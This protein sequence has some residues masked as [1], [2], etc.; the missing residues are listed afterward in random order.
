VGR[1]GNP[2]DEVLKMAGLEPAEIHKVEVV[3]G[4]WRIPQVQ[5]TLMERTKVSQL[6]KTMN[7]DEAFCFGSALYAAS[8]STAFR[9]RKFGVHDIT[10]FPVSIDMDALGSAD[11]VEEDSEEGG[12]DKDAT[13]AGGKKNIKLFKIG[14]KIPSKRLLTF[15]RDSDLTFTLR[16]DDEVPAYVPAVI[17]RYNITGVQ[18]AV[19]KYPNGT[20]PKINVSFRLTRTGLVEVDRAEAAIEEMVEV[21]VCEWVKSNETEEEAAAEEKKEGDEEK[22]EGEE[23]K[24]EG[25]EEKKEGDEEKKE[26]EEEKKEGEEEKK[27]GDEEKKEGEE[28]KKDGDEEKK[29]GEEEKKEGEEEKK[30]GEEEKKDDKKKKKKAKKVR[31]CKMK[32]EKQIHR[33]ALK[34]AAETPIPRPFTAEQFKETKQQLADYDAREQ[35]I[36]DRASAF[37][38]L[39]SYIYN[40][41]E[42][43]ENNEEMKEVTTDKMRKSFAEDLK[44][45]GTW[46]EDD[47]W[48]APTEKLKEKLSELTEIGDPIFARM[49]QRLER[50]D[51][52]KKAHKV[53]TTAE[54]AVANLTKKMPWL[55][56]S[57]TEMVT[58]KTEALRTWL[59][60]V[61]EKQEK[62]P[63]HEAPVFTVE[64]LYRKFPAIE[65]SLKRLARVPKPIEKKEKKDKKKDKKEDKEDKEGPDDAA[66]DTEGGG[67]A[68][69]KEGAEGDGGKEDEKAE[70]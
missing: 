40:V 46:I 47:G 28:E 54:G 50:P 2:V 59:A 16:Y 15:K 43:L 62:A 18:K 7:S 39:E 44:K 34:V 24:K 51:A 66:E 17:A 63:A 25:E 9:L 4:G 12:E 27:D 8:L 11:A 1:V 49:K 29:E 68:E 26:G 21:E 38:S 32:E 65:E 70:L 64:E 30:E 56:E 42:K 22:K 23:E 48:E 37:N 33:V 69:D 10:S 19:E 52:I 67:K 41:Q 36:R 3:G 13:A 58:N 53:L 5:D 60:E 55:N 20:K 57:H 35:K 14:H 6:A 45:M 61:T 31:V